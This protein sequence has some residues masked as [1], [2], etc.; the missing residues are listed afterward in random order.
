VN[1]NKENSVSANEAAAL[2]D[3]K[4]NQTFPFKSD[5]RICTEKSIFITYIY[6]IHLTARWRAAKINLARANNVITTRQM[7]V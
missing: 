1:E 7:Y 4:A 6:N 5:D 3:S 2:S